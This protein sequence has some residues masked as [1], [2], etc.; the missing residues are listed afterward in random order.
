MQT[1]DYECISSVEW[2]K[3]QVDTLRHR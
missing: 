1:G 2:L 3:P